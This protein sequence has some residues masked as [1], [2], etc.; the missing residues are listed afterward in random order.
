MW[1]VSLFQLY[2]LLYSDHT[3]KQ[4][5]GV[6]N[7]CLGGKTVLTWNRINGGQN[8]NQ[9]CVLH[10]PCWYRLL[11]NQGWIKS[12][13]QWG[14]GSNILFPRCLSN[15]TWEA[16]KQRWAQQLLLPLHSFVPSKWCWKTYS[17]HYCSSLA[18]R[19]EI[20]NLMRNESIFALKAFIFS[21][22]S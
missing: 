5:R 16:Y 15:Y 2:F 9:E 20:L 6:L 18:T 4:L 7:L 14:K 13:Q 19:L 12:T 22:Q 3:K 10:I 17:H 8:R 11:L 21:Q 1:P